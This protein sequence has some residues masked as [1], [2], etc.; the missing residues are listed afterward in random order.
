MWF[1]VN[2]LLSLNNNSHDLQPINLI[3]KKALFAWAQFRGRFFFI[4]LILF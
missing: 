2:C 3:E 1:A 4:S